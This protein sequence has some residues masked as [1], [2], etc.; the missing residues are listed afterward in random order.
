MRAVNVSDDVL[1]WLLTYF[2]VAQPLTTK[3]DAHTN[4][5]N[6]SLCMC[7]FFLRIA[8]SITGTTMGVCKAIAVY[9]RLRRS[10]SILFKRSSSVV[11]CRIRRS[12]CWAFAFA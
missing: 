11:S 2:F 7:L 3:M 12:L 6:E 9:G 5:R 8:G 10:A 4:K 1:T